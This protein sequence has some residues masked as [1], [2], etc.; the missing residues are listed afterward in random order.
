MADSNLMVDQRTREAPAKNG[1]PILDSV[2]LW[3]SAKLR[4]ITLWRYRLWLT[5]HARAVLAQRRGRPPGRIG[6]DAEHLRAAAEWLAVAQD[7]TADGGVVGR[8]RLDKGWTSSY[9]E[10]TGYIVP[11]FLAL[12]DAVD[13]RYRD[14]AGR[15]VKF[16]LSTQ[17][18]SGAF[19][20]GEIDD[21]STKPSPFNTGQII[22]GLLSWHRREGDAASVSAAIRAGE[23]LLSVQDADGAWRRFCYH[24]LPSCYSAHLSCWLADLGAHCRD[25]RFL[26]G[27]A[28]HLDWVLAQRCAETGWFDRC[29]F[30]AEEHELRV[31]DLHTIS[32]T[33]AGV[34]RMGQ[35]LQ[36]RDAIAAV[37]VAAR[38]IANVIERLGWLPGALDWQWRGRVDSVSLTGNAQIALIWMALY[39]E[40]G[41]AAWLRP[42]FTAIDLV[43][44]RQLLDSPN[45][46]LRGGIPGSYP[47]WGRYKGGMLLSWSTK[48]FIDA[49]LRKAAIEA[50]R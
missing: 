12:A 45:P 40:T 11:T 43:K 13:P 39:E 47:I 49:L 34:L 2:E 29:G 19:P 30:T 7:A 33:L 37:L 32:Y 24:N 3:H 1:P 18:S 22:H 44:Q 8:Y 27:A 31:A 38:A 41:D 5:G 26:D 25:Q 16:L 36:R 28:R 35:V 21:N 15:S 10:T 14:R 23:W 42:A 6:P 9:P 17:L 48:F 50:A 20:G 46:S 4:P